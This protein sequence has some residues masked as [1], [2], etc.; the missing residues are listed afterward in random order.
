MALRQRPDWLTWYFKGDGPQAPT[1]YLI[2]GTHGG[3]AR[4]DDPRTW[5]P[6]AKAL[7]DYN[8]GLCDGL[9]YAAG[10]IPLCPAEIAALTEAGVLIWGCPQLPV[11]VHIQHRLE[12]QPSAAPSGE[13]S[14]IPPAPVPA[15]AKVPPSADRGRYDAREDS[16][17]VLRR[18]GERESSL[19][20]TRVAP[21]KS[22]GWPPLRRAL[23]EAL[24]AALLADGPLP[25]TVLN[26]R[27]AALG[28]TTKTRRN[29]EARL[30]T[31]RWKETTR[32]GAWWVALPGQ[33]AK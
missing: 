4:V 19:P 23:A 21:P 1:V 24:I 22:G 16:H 32:D 11:P 33:R 20:T 27:C 29:A 3:R 12:P 6:F 2:P 8:Q 17:P 10:G 25:R 7:A 14:C 26:A 18:G 13:E 9:A 30:H 31:V 15:P 28:I 5:R